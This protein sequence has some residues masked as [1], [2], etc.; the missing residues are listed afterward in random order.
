[1][2]RGD[3]WSALIRGWWLIV[4]FGLIGLGLGL[5]S[6]RSHV[7]TQFVSVSAVGSPPPQTTNGST[8]TLLSANQIMY[9]GGTDAVLTAAS[10]K[11]GLNWPAWVVR[12]RLTL[13]G[14]PLQNS[15]GPTSGQAGVINVRVAAPSTADSLALNNAFDDALGDEVNSV[16]Q[17]SLNASVTETQGKLYSI[18]TE[19]AT[20]QFPPGVTPEALGIQVSALQSYLATLVVSTPSTGYSVLHTAV[21]QE[22]SKQ[23]SGAALNSRKLR[24]AAGLLFGVL[25]GALLAMAMWLLDRRL[26][27][28][29]RA[30]L[31]FGYPV[32]A[33]IPSAASDSTEPYRMLWL[34]VFREPLPLP[35]L[36]GTEPLYDGESPLIDAGVG[37]RSGPPEIT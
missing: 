34:S 33:E 13:Q 35:P 14:P 24:A 17:S 30:Q 8:G 31:A 23:T 11:A 3:Y 26:K 9:Y 27:T 21:V 4:V 12:D 28:A 29:K 6:P 5:I 25:V 18:M 16:A 1:M 22:V 20:K 15:T 37:S 19:L 10:K 32:V 36:D 7:S 2:E